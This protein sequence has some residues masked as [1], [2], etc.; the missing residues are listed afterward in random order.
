MELVGASEIEYNEPKG[1]KPKM[2]WRAL[3]SGVFWQE[4]KV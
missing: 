4:A 3:N 1:I 2:L